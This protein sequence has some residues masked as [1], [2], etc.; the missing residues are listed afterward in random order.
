[1]PDVFDTAS[2]DSN[3]G[4][5]KRR[6]YDSALRQSQAQQTRRA[7][8]EAG[9]ALITEHGYARTTMRQIAARA[10]VSVETVYQYFKSKPAVLRALLDIALDGE[11]GSRR[12]ALPVAQREW[13]RRV[14][15]E[16]D[17]P[18]KL[19]VLAQSVTAVHSRLAP[20][21][22]A[23]RAA[24]EADANAAEIWSARKAERFDGLGEFAHQL[25]ASGQLPAAAT[26]EGVRDLLFALTSPELY[27][28]LVLELHWPPERYTTWLT[29]TLSQQLLT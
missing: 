9:Q 11:T 20:L 24:A 7:V 25:L 21:L 1:M 12:E 6:H 8:L 27:G 3:S 15:A 19:A 5:V 13:V 26:D 10:G 23:A 4:D 17:V 16:P 29:S 14:R 22:L 28:L 18:R 2:V